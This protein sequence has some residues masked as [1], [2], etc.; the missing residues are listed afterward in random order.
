[1]NTCVLPLTL[2]QKKFHKGPMF[3]IFNKR[4]KGTT[5]IDMSGLGADMHSHLI[6]GVDDG[7]EDVD[8]SIRL[9]KGMH[10]LGFSKLITTPHVMWEM[11]KNNT[12]TILNGYRLVQER[13]EKENI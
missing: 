5:S 4:S 6:P 3:S 12:E 9:I 13:L 1:M 2:R 8:M 10:E 11:Y 7:A